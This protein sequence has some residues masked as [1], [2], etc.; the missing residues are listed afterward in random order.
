MLRINQITL[1][2]NDREEMLGKYICAHLGIGRR[3]L[4]SYSVYKRS[5]DARKKDIKIVY[6]VD[7]VVSDESKILSKK[8]KDVSVITQYQYTVPSKG[9]KKMRHR[10]IV[11]G[12]G[13]AG[14][15]AALLLAKEGYRPIVIERGS[16]ME[17]RVEKVERFWKEGILDPSCNVQFGEGGAGTFSDGKL[18]TRVKD[19]RSRK[20]L[21]ELVAAGAKEEILQEAHPHIGTDKLRN[22]VRNIREQI[23][24]LGGSFHFNT[25]VE[26]LVIEDGKVC[27]V[28]TK[29]GI[30][31]SETVLLC[32]GHS[33]RD[34]Y[35]ALYDHSITMTPKAFAVGVRVEHKQ[36]EIDVCQYGDGSLAKKLGAA[37]YYLT[38]TADNGR[39]VFSFCMCPGGVVVPS[40]S[41]IDSIV[42]NGM[43]YAARDGENANSAILVQ[44]SPKDY[45]EGILSGIAF[46]EMLEKRAYVMGKG[47]YK[48]PAQYIHDYLDH[49]IST[50]LQG[51]QPS[52]ALGVTLCNMHELFPKDI[53]VA[54][55]QGL[56]AFTRKIKGFEKGIMI[57][58]E[59]RS[60]SP[61]RVERD[62]QSLQ[63]VSVKG[64]YPCGEGCGYAGGIVSAAID[65]LKVAEEVI[66]V[67]QP[68]KVKEVK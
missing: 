34:T 42:T 24:A 45:G 22:V 3:D 55:T 8:I 19:P 37:E 6:T 54:L 66:K 23:I 29:K 62:T 51:V 68:P 63:S 2:V 25:L 56:Q 4:V 53:D 57:G 20:V 39:G 38:H 27:G 50:E 35:Q 67:Y 18:T 65:G 7:V 16:K 9:N 5:I 64:L 44:V 17:E 30:L 21:E 46:Q 10:P 47:G 61:V 52:Y 36:E 11:V 13:P 26:D 1:S 41:E 58:V 59:T 40:N 60:S 48:A 14:M 28:V 12:F 15:F 43:S 49:T 32:I 31:K 33:A